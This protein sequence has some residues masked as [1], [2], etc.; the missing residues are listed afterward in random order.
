MLEI[1]RLVAVSVIIISVLG[2]NAFLIYNQVDGWGWF[3]VASF[4]INVNLKG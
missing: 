1:V 2:M 4:L 3:L